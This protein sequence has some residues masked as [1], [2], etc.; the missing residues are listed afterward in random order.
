MMSRKTKFVV[1]LLA[2]TVAGVVV[3]VWLMLGRGY[4]AKDEPTAIEAF[5]ARRVRS[6]ATPR[7][8]RDAQNP[9]ENSAPV[10]AEAMA[11]FADHCASCHAN[12]GSGDTPLGRGFYPKPPDLRKA[13]TQDLSDG[14]LFYIIH[15]GIRLTGMPA[16]GQQSADQDTDSWKLVRF[17]RYLPTISSEE[18]EK[19]KAMNP[20]SAHEMQEEEAIRRFLAGD[21][22][23]PTETGHKHDL[24]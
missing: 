7:A 16:F 18:L 15:N 19:M 8:A 9:V 24:P 17:I 3:P 2:L 20:K 11:H 22:S 6:L 12:D 23:R 13:D 5:I 1:A 10:I 14:E 21:D 4:S